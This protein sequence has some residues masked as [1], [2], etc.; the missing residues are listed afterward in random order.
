MSGGTRRFCARANENA[1]TR[2][3]TR[4][5]RALRP[6]EKRGENPLRVELRSPDGVYKLNVYVQQASKLKQTLLQVRD[7]ASARHLVGGDRRGALPPEPLGGLP[8]HPP[9]PPRRAARPPNVAPRPPTAANRRSPTFRSWATSGRWR[10]WCCPRG[11]WWQRPIVWCWSSLLLT[12][13]RRW[14]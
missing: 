7:S 4:L 8:A 11:R 12:L 3:C 1:C 14:G 9:A 13:A 6:A 5:E 10:G 2:L